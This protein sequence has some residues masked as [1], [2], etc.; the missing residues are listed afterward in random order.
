MQ[1]K[2]LDIGKKKS[3]IQSTKKY[4]PTYVKNKMIR[5]STRERSNNNN[6]YYNL[7]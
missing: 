1:Y 7:L 5:I 4:I 3:R 6:N 2:L